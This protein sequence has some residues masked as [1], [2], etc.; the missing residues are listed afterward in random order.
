LALTKKEKYS[1]FDFDNPL[2][3]M[4]FENIDYEDFFDE[5]G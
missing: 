4:L 1:W 2:D 3:Y 5:E